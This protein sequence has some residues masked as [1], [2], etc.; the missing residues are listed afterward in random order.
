MF[1]TAGRR[2]CAGAGPLH[3]DFIDD[4]IKLLNDDAA[5]ELF[6]CI[7]VALVGVV[8]GTRKTHI[9]FCGRV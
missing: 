2:G 4:T 3:C 5:L 9:I 7:I 8:T 1:E 6:V